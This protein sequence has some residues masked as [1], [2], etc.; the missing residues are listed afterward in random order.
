MPLPKNLLLC[1]V[2][3]TLA[4]GPSMAPTEGSM[5]GT[6]S[7]SETSAVPTT[8]SLSSESTSSTGSSTT[9]NTV[10]SSVDEGLSPECDILAQNCGE[11]KKCVPVA[12]INGVW[13]FSA[14]VPVVGD[15]IAGDA[16]NTQGD[17]GVDDCAAGYLCWNRDPQGNGVC[18]GLCMGDMM[19]PVCG[20]GFFCAIHSITLFL[21]LPSCD[22]LT[23]DCVGG[24]NCV[25]DTQHFVCVQDVSG[26]DGEANDPCESYGDCNPGLLCRPG[27][28]VSAACKSEAACCT[29]FCLLSEGECP[30]PDQSCISWY[31]E[32]EAPPG[33]ENLGLCQV[34]PG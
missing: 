32:G 28:E 8:S 26:A 27:G 1:G 15:G 23:Q 21:C 31:A 25:E 22:P 12:N 6:G 3:A 7:P 16:C 14:C 2:L 30:N 4:C 9:A 19:A 34:D 17:N 11:G 20:E 29:P 5:G 18:V 10:G 33:Q 24:E 13:N